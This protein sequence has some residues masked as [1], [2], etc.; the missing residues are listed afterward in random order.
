[1]TRETKHLVAGYATDSLAEAE[2]QELLL[3]ALDDQALFDA[4][5]EEDGL[6]EL[7]QDPAARQEVLA[8]LEEPTFWRARARVVRAARDAR[9]T[10]EPSRRSCSRRS[11][12]T[13]SSR[14]VP[15]PASRTPAAA[16]PMGAALS[17]RHVAWLLAVAGAAG[18][19]GGDR[20]RHAAP[21]PR[22]APGEPI[23]LRVSLRAPA[24]VALL[25]QPADR[26]AAQVWPGL[27]Q[28]P[29]LVPRPASGGPAI[30]EVSLETPAQEGPHRLRLVVAPADL[31]LGALAPEALP[32]CRE[33]AHD[34]RS[35]LP[36]DPPMTDQAPQTL[37]A[38]QSQLGRVILGKPEAIDHLLV[39][40]LARAPPPDGGRAGRRQDDARQGAR[41]RVLG[42]VPARAVHAGP[43]AHRHPRLVG[44]Q[45][46]GRQLQLQGRARSSRTCC[47]PTRSTAPRRAR[48]RLCSR[49]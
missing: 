32:G 5:V 47:S 28:P 30:Q 43:A 27:G 48:S 42:R 6:R 10:S 39:A 4:L 22:F 1:M 13:R 17:T 9:S 14:F 3:A 29:A 26:P 20:D 45:P 12:A 24:R 16:R 37:A 38:L 33:P 18:R 31:D 2:R 25:E 41:A 19:P 49:R 46:E 8:V 34:R 35:S 40:L 21:T 15:L 23:H 44:L 11:P 36:G 7:L